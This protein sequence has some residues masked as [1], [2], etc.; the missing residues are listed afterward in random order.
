MQ[1]SATNIAQLKINRGLVKFIF[2]TFITF[3]IYALVFYSCIS[4][5]INTI[6]SRYDGKR[7]MHFCLLAF[8]LTPITFGIAP[9]VWYHKLSNRIGAELSR[10]G[11]NYTFSAGTFW[12]WNVL[13]S[14]IFVGPFVYLHKL[15]AAMN[16]LSADYNVRG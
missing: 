6:A 7:T 15:C 1:N 13:G 4:S 3:G 2:L 5:D 16:A 8:I 11:I 10:R 14:I 9:I 12:G